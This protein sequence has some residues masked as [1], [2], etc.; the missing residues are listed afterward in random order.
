MGIG[1]AAILVTRSPNAV[2]MEASIARTE[3][4]AGV[5]EASVYLQQAGV[6]RDYRKQILESFEIETISLR[7]ADN[8]TYGLRFYGGIAKESGRY[9]FPTFN[10]YIN[11][12]G[13]ALPPKWN[14]MSG[15]TQFK[16]APG[17]PYVFGRAAS[18]GGIYTG[19]SLQMYI[20]D[21]K[22]LTK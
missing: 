2:K 15:F 16:I 6:P 10:N 18:Q 17:T 13:L 11:R 12:V 9:L 19:G 14:T 3:A 4:Y 22:N 1:L 5:R 8:S 7:T 20:N 21:V